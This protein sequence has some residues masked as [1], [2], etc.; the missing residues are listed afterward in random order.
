MTTSNASESGF[1]Q[2]YV[3]NNR[4]LRLF[5]VFVGVMLFMLMIFPDLLEMPRMDENI[6]VYEGWLIAKG[7][8]PYRDF[9]EFL[10]PLTPYLSGA[11]MALSNN[12]LVAL[13][14]VALVCLLSCIAITLRLVRP[15]LPTPWLFFLA[16]VLWF[17]QFPL[18][19]QF[20]H[21]LIDTTMSLIAVWF[22]SCYMQSAQ[23]R[24]LGL[25]GLFVGLTGLATQSFGVTLFIGLNVFLILFTLK[26]SSSNGPQSAL[27]P[28]LGL[29]F[30]SAFSPLLLLLVY[31]WSIGNLAN[32]WQMTVMWVMQGT[33]A[34]TTMSW[35]FTEGFLKL[36]PTTPDGSIHVAPWYD[37]VLTL[38]LGW[39]P[40]L[41][42][43]WPVDVIRKKANHH[44]PLFWHLMLLWIAGFS[45]WV[46]VFSNPN[47]MVVGYHS[48]LLY[49]LAAV[50]LYYALRYHKKTK[51]VVGFLLVVLLSTQLFFLSLRSAYMSTRPY[52]TSFGTAE[53]MMLAPESMS[54]ESIEW[55]D[56]MINGI[57]DH[58]AEDDPIF[59]YNQ[60]PQLYVMTNRLNATRYYLM[61]KHYSPQSEIDEAFADLKAASPRYIIYDRKDVQAFHYDMRFEK[62][63]GQDHRL[64]PIDKWVNDHYRGILHVDDYT[65]YK[66]NFTP[67]PKPE[68]TPTEP[69][70]S[71]Q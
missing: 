38:M 40:V 61:M 46:G 35:Y 54:M 71:A 36:F 13:R 29:F 53:G 58:T 10:T 5:I 42:L 7:M 19:F 3:M 11:V 32:F 68:E 6:Y 41:G 24:H 67:S 63:R 47:R 43:I 51:W 62:Y 64:L 22:V 55:M 70:Q 57:Y 69:T 14:L 49:G 52:L 16:F 4:I 28:R 66:S 33:Y 65:V 1:W 20:Q 60:S 45:L 2:H 34:D 15:F 25:A 12:S 30:V 27:L 18:N 39:L 37:F 8:V 31:Y 56:T 48:F 59:I 23:A 26:A 9:F 21:H 50:A 44:H 17:I